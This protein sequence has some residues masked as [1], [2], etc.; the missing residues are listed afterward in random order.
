MSAINFQFAG[1]GGR[2][3]PVT[4][5]YER[6]R[7]SA[8]LALDD[9]FPFLFPRL[10]TRKLPPPAIAAR[11]KGPSTES[12][13]IQRISFCFHSES[14]TRSQ[15]VVPTST[16][17]DCRAVLVAMTLT[18]GTE[19]QHKRKRQPILASP[20]ASKDQFPGPSRLG[21]DFSQSDPQGAQPRGLSQRRLRLETSRQGYVPNLFPIRILRYDERTR[22]LGELKN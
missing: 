3:P 4:P 10:V 2:V 13:L 7:R 16:S 1:H 5:Y 6:V 18:Q 20:S 19:P 17:H 22:A 8:A 11:A 15:S 12:I 9:P 14:S 21:R